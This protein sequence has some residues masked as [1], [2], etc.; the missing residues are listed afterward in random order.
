MTTTKIDELKAR[1]KEA[2]STV[3]D[4][5]VYEC[6]SIDFGTMAMSENRVEVEF[7]A[8]KVLGRYPAR[9]KEMRAEWDQR[10]R[11][12]HKPAIAA[13]KA[14]LRKARIKFVEIDNGKGIK[15]LLLK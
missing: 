7:S 8:L 3:P 1:A 12:L 11:D 14:A 6:S 15:K 10:H 5:W 9:D 4:V 2:L 13:A